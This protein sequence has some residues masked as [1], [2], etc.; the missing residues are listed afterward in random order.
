MLQL[1]LICEL[2]FSDNLWYTGSNI[3]NHHFI[4]F[5]WLISFFI[6]TTI[7][8]MYSHW[9]QFLMPPSACLLLA[10]IIILP[11]WNCSPFFDHYVLVNYLLLNT[12]LNMDYPIFLFFSITLLLI[13]PYLNA[14]SGVLLICFLLWMYTAYAIVAIQSSSINPTYINNTFISYILSYYLFPPLSIVHT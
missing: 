3:V 1:L 8:I 4:M 5:A 7:I 2:G 11:I 9:D 6:P 14:W 10:I 13:G 12:Y